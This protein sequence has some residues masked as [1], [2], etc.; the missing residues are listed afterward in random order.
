MLPKRYW[1]ELDFVG[2]VED[3][4]DESVYGAVLIFQEGVWGSLPRLLLLATV[5]TKGDQCYCGYAVQAERAGLAPRLSTVPQVDALAMVG[6]G[7][8]QQL[9]R[10]TGLI[11]LQADGTLGVAGSP[12]SP[13][14]HAVGRPWPPFLALLFAPPP[15][16]VTLH[17]SCKKLDAC[18]YGDQDAGDPADWQNQTMKK[19]AGMVAEAPYNAIPEE[20]L[21]QEDD[22]PLL[23]PAGLPPKPHVHLHD[24]GRHG[25]SFDL[26]VTWCHIPKAW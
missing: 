17:A 15:A 3:R 19:A 6:M 7:A 18:Y 8:G 24:E 9:Q 25:P 11:C 10:L 12:P 20:A 5:C 1:L 14:S 21:I 13:P 23:S 2:R 4:A 26:P 22:G 16:L